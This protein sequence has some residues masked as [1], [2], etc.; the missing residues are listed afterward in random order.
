LAPVTS[1]SPEK[2]LAFGVGAKYLFKFKGSGEETR[3]SNL[4]MSVQYTL[5]N[6]FFIYSGFE[7]F[8]NQEEWVIEGNFLFQNYPRL[9]YGIG[10]DTAVSNEEEYNYYQLLFEPIFLKQMFT[11]YL[12]IGG[13]VRI[14]HIYNTEV[15]E[16]GLIDLNMPTGFDGSTSVGLETALLYD[17]RN[18]LLNATSGWYFEGT[19][20][21]Y[22]DLVGSSHNFRLLRYDLRHYF[23]INNKSKD[24]LA[25]Q[26]IGRFSRGDIPFSEYSF[27]GGS[28]IM[29]GYREGRYVDRDM[30]ATQLEYRKSFINSR[31]GAVAFLGFGNVYNNISD[32]KLNEL[33]PNYGV[34]L[35]FK[36]DK[37]EN[38]NI[39]LDW[40]FSDNK[41]NIYFG[42]A[43][44]F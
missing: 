7:M 19:Y 11:R 41:S 24:V 23:S 13:G 35:R 28:D 36:I 9:Y 37:S 32:L 2:S 31:L 44:A 33:K 34:G 14:N 15:E 20:G 42:I 21:I 10:N 8:T 18:N 17:N 1:Y 40:G 25:V 22:D 3:T 6:Q 16:N 39:R 12:F 30:I 27:F 29:R 43:E 26:T 38:L 5:N 4:P